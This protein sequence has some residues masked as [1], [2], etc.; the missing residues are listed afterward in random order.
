MSLLAPSIGVKGVIVMVR[1]GG[2]QG[3]REKEGE[4]ERGGKEIEIE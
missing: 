4:R 2:R 3:K 1:K